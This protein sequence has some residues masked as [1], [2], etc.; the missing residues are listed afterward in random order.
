M[1]LL[2]LS[3]RI[4]YDKMHHFLTRQLSGDWL[5][6][7]AGPFCVLGTSTVLVRK[8]LLGIT[9]PCAHCCAGP[10]LPLALHWGDIHSMYKSMD[11][12]LLSL[13]RM[14]QEPDT[15]AESVTLMI[16]LLIWAMAAWSCRVSASR[17][18]AICNLQSSFAMTWGA[19]ETTLAGICEV[20][21]PFRKL[22]CKDR[23]GHLHSCEVL[24]VL[25]QTAHVLMAP[26]LPAS[27]AEIVR[28]LPSIETIRQDMVTRPVPSGKLF[29][30]CHNSH[31]LLNVFLAC[32]YTCEKIGRP[33]QAMAYAVAGL[34]RDDSLGGTPLVMHRVLLL[35][36]QARALAALG[37]PH[38][39]APV[40][41]QAADEARGAGLHLY[42]LHDTIIMIMNLD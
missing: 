31:V 42:H 10:C 30:M 5:V 14:L 15:A 18:Q 41:T 25:A 36:A 12:S 3:L 7:A 40:F 11:Q 6:A 29:I 24:V 1:S 19:S 37:R 17:R 21:T 26:E 2:T 27:E 4:D 34:V 23:D 13:R 16:G 32:A 28:R 35:S 39:A 9:Q 20:L 33:D 38:E 8:V 22:G